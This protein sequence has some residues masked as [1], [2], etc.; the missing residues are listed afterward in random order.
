MDTQD[1]AQAHQD[2]LTQVAQETQQSQQPQEQQAQGEQ[3]YQDSTVAELKDELADRDLPKS[4]NKDDL[5]ARLEES[6]QT[7]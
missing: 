7:Q 4:G 6:D 1:A 3:S 2:V 5:V